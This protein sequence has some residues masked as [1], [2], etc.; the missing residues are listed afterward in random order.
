[1]HPEQVTGSTAVEATL[2]ISPSTRARDYTAVHQAQSVP[3]KQSGKLPVF[4]IR[5]SL[6][7]ISLHICT[8]TFPYENCKPSCRMPQSKE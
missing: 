3:Q 8:L 2:D 6:N 4:L 1:M 7:T 5:E